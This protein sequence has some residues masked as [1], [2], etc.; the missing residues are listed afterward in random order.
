MGNGRIDESAS[1]MD[2]P[3]HDS[4]GLSTLAPPT[5]RDPDHMHSESLWSY[6]SAPGRIGTSG[7]YARDGDGS[8]SLEI[9]R[10]N[11][12]TGGW[13][14]FVVILCSPQSVRNITE[15]N[16]SASA[17]GN[18]IGGTSEHP[19]HEHSPY[20]QLVH[21]FEFFILFFLIVFFAITMRLSRL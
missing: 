15:S 8:N 7:E 19:S 1:S 12:S 18:G 3:N 9:P 21:S 4:G 16:G 17:S 13:S 14:P 20:I 5:L 10:E 2:L 6:R 11:K